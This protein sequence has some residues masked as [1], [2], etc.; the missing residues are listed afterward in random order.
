M[1]DSIII[2]Q[3]RNGGKFIQVSESQSIRHLVTFSKLAYYH[4][5]KFYNI[6]TTIHISPNIKIHAA[7]LRR[8]NETAKHFGGL[9]SK[10]GWRQHCRR[11]PRFN[12]EYLILMKGNHL[13]LC[14]QCAVCLTWAIWIKF[15]VICPSCNGDIIS[16]H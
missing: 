5:Y 9:L 14:S 7:K 8:K 4:N 12:D 16:T 6:T 15:N 1:S 2:F 13:L 11:H 3:I 10:K